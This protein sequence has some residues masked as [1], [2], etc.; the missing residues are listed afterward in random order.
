M[1]KD[2]S[3][4]DKRWADIPYPRKPYC[5]KLN[6][7]GPTTCADLIAGL[8]DPTITPQDTATWM[9]EHGYA[10]PGHGTAWAGMPACLKAYGLVDVEY[11]TMRAAWPNFAKRKTG[12]A[13]M[14]KGTRGGVTWTKS[15]HYIAIANYKEKDGKH[16]FYIC[17]PGARKHDGWYCYEDTM[18]GMVKQIHV[19]TVADEKPKKKTYKGFDVSYAQSDLKKADFRKAKKAGWDYVIIRAGTILGGKYHKDSEFESKFKNAKAAGLKV[20]IYWYGMA[21]DTKT[22]KKEAKFV[23]EILNSREVDYP[24]FYDLE[25]KKQK[26][27]GKDKNKKIAEAY[28]AVI[29]KAGYDAGVYAS[30][31]WLTNRIAAINKKYAVWLAQYPTATYK[32]RYE[33]H[34]YTSSGAVDG[35]G[36]RI[37]CDTTTLAPQ[38]KPKK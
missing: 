36:N 35:I 23:L 13:L 27:L 24:I 3:Q 10:V 33:M 20:G 12:Y 16:Y 8:V 34:Q 22:A 6:G 14:G 26:N 30:Y 17:D 19:V 5:V 28:C 38:K 4:G 1:L 21:T 15:G 31:D 2:Y 11:Q 25:D 29:E 9:V 37:D 7:C 32:G 18:Y